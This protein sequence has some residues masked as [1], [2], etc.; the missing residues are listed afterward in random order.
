MIPRASR[1]MLAIALATG[2]LAIPHVLWAAD[3]PAKA[4]AEPKAEQKEKKAD[5]EACETGE[6]KCCGSGIGA[7]VAQYGLDRLYDLGD[8]FRIRGGVPQDGKGAGVKAR[9]TFLAQAGFVHFNGRYAGMNGR[10]L[11]VTSEDRTE[12]GLSALYGS[13]HETYAVCANDFQRGDT[14][15]SAVEDRRLLLNLPYWD[16]GRGDLLGVGA[17][18]ATPLLAIDLGVSPSQAVDFLAGI[19]TIDPYKD[20][21]LTIDFDK[22][23][24]R[25]TRTIPAD[26]DPDYA[27]SK[28]Q[29]K[30]DAANAEVERLRMER[31]GASEERVAGEERPVE[32]L[33]RVDAPEEPK[34]DAAAPA[35]PEAPLD[36][37]PFV[38]TPP[39]VP[40]V[41]PPA[42]EL[43]SVEAP[44]APTEMPAESKETVGDAP[45]TGEAVET[46]EENATTVE[47]VPPPEETSSE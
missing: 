8:I 2:A 24:A 44:A 21:I 26:V 9:A 23:N 27:G 28:R 11:G 40:A 13:K 3:E 33:E 10:G 20:D 17:E 36:A 12:G 4:E 25:R 43:P 19:F 37:P 22:S 46:I 35:A 5:A 18:V 16:D 41:D 34:A 47:F 39:S 42:V 15:W 32:A 7:S 30:I 45:L 29:A 14:P 6:C 1:R 38:E 31:E